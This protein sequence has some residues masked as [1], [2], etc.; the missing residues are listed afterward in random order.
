[1]KLALPLLLISLLSSADTAKVK[2]IRGEVTALLPHASKAINLKKGDKLPEDTSIVTSMKSI[3]KLKLKD[4]SIISLG[5]KSKIVLHTMNATKEINVMGILKG[6]LRA[7][8]KKERVKDPKMII[9]TR[10][11]VMGVRGTTFKMVFNPATNNTTL[12]TIE[13][14]VAMAK[15]QE[16]KPSETLIRKKEIIEAAEATGDASKIDEA[17][18][19]VQEVEK[20]ATVKP[21]VVEM[22]EAL[23]S[24]EVVS[25]TKGQ[26]SGVVADLAKP[27]VPV[28]VAPKQLIALV[29]TD[30][31]A[32]KIITKSDEDIIKDVYSDSEVTREQ[33]DMHF[34]KAAGKLAPRAGGLIDFKSGL[35]VPPAKNSKYDKDNHIFVANDNIGKVDKVGNYVPPKG[36]RIDDKNGFVVD[37]KE[38]GK[39]ASNEELKRVQASVGF[40]NNQVKDQVHED[41]EVQKVTT[42]KRFWKNLFKVKNHVLSAAITPKSNIY[43][44]T[45]K[46]S[47]SETDLF[48]QTAN[49]V[50]LTWTVDWQSKWRTDFILGLKKVEMKDP[51]GA[52][53]KI[54]NKGIMKKLNINLNYQYSN[55]LTLFFGIGE[56]D[57]L[58]F[59]PDSEG[60]IGGF[61][62]SVGRFI[63]GGKYRV[64]DYKKFEFFA[65]GSFEKLS[66]T[67]VEDPSGTSRYDIGKGLGFNVTGRAVYNYRERYKLEGIVFLGNSTQTINDYLEQSTTSL[68]IGASFIWD[69]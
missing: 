37:T 57:N 9:K 27:T 23:K 19:A 50:D 48:S 20:Q 68:G 66:D 58:Y 13:G 6:V 25:V 39:L 43:G 29:K 38:L 63:I 59:I 8:V 32:D 40:L 4:G 1:M 56:E 45:N 7:E 14:E 51:D 26:F 36:V 16:A 46:S 35:Y 5:P 65:E 15:V 33:A 69:I 10:S 53:L 47:G 31:L 11:A 61:A 12:V 2:F 30:E 44:L 28:K 42:K 41:K 60:F 18:I 54:F 34:D 24:K 49:D 55:K 22:K 52:T 64:Y 21:D 67:T 62:A 3:V 17:R